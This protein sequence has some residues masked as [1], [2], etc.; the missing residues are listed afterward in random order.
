M[1]RWVF[2]AGADGSRRLGEGRGM[3][4]VAWNTSGGA[5]RKGS[6]HVSG[7]R[8]AWETSLVGRGHVVAV[9]GPSVRVRR[10]RDASV[11]ARGRGQGVHGKGGDVRRV[12]FSFGEKR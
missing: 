5:R 12:G 7:G 11:R 10:G 4:G 3:W 6:G 2:A 1:E 9:G 8:G